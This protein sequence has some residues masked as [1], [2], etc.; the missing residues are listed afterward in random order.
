MPLS[1]ASCWQLWGLLHWKSYQRMSASG[2]SPDLKL[3][4][5]GSLD[6]SSIRELVL[7]RKS[8]WMLLRKSKCGQFLPEIPNCSHITGSLIA[9]G[10]PRVAPCIGND[11]SWVLLSHLVTVPGLLRA[12]WQHV[13]S[14]KEIC[15][16]CTDG[17]KQLGQQSSAT[18]S[19]LSTERKRRTTH[20]RRKH[21]DRMLL[22]NR[23]QNSSCPRRG[24]PYEPP[25]HL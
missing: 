14:S 12:T 6:V 16:T 8:C 4:V 17:S 1:S 20:C 10:N 2:V 22:M 5:S 11:V 18:E 21:V 19:Q 3:Q 25:R 24:L 23:E 9:F 15:H 7:Y 13:T